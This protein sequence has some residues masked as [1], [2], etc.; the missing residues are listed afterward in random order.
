[1]TETVPTTG[2][3]E[4]GKAQV[5]NLKPGDKLPEGWH[6]APKDWQ[7]PNNPD[8]G[9]AR[10]SLPPQNVGGPDRADLDTSKPVR[11]KK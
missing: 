8:F 7:H 1:M 3:D 4:N 6:S 11:K 10:P 5:F 9:K 2:Y